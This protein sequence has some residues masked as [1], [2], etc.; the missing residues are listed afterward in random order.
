[1]HDYND[2]KQFDADNTI[3]AENIDNIYP[4]ANTITNKIRK[5]MND[6]NK[7]TKGED[8]TK[9]NSTQ[10]KDKIFHL[11]LENGI[12]EENK[13]INIELNLPPNEQ[14]KNGSID[15]SPNENKENNK[16]ENEVKFIVNNNNNNGASNP[17]ALKKKRKFLVIKRPKRIRFDNNRSMLARHILNAYYLPIINKIIK[18]NF[19]FKLKKFPK[20]FTNTIINKTNKNY[21]DYSLEE[22]Y[23]HENLKYN[24]KIIDIINNDKYKE[25]R[26]KSGLEK[27]LKMKFRDLIEEYLEKNEYHKKIEEMKKKDEQFDVD[28]FIHSAKDFIKNYN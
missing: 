24:K 26:E 14:N 7:C 20:S 10:D 22:F 3:P 19:N 11:T 8:Y 4:F 1:M 17:K 15:E 2:A 6:G 13:S 12:K 28:N 25:L 18:I 21:L 5:L 23:N 9:E 16:K 27:K